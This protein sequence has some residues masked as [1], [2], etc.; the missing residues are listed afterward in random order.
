[1][2]CNGR[3][4]EGYTEA[5][6]HWGFK[7]NEL[8]LNSNV[9]TMS[10]REIAELTG[11]DHAD[12]LKDVRKVLEEVGIDGGK[13]SGVYKGANN[14]DR[15]CFNLPRRECDLVIAGYSAKYR[16]AIIDRWIE[17]EAKNVKTPLQLAREQVILYERL[18][19]SQAALS[20]AVQTKAE[21]GSRREATAMNTASQAVKKVTSLEIELDKSMLYSTIKRMEIIHHGLKFNWRLLKSAG[22]QM[23]IESIDVFDANYG[24]IK[25]YHADVWLEAY[26][27]GIE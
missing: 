2:S 5:F 25:A 12:V 4:S 20:M 19:A 17:L 22:T 1:V 23:G 6:L 10:S 11:K 24:T 21:I 14:Q 27:I 3:N 15:P 26:A 7:M 13:F 9:S 8:T 16:L 18:E